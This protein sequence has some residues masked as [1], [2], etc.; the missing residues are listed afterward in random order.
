MKMQYATELHAH[1]CLVS[2]CA[3]LPLEDAVQRYAESG[4]HTVVV[5]DHYC[6]YVIDT[7]GET[8]EQVVAHYV[9]GYK[10]M[11][12]MAKGKFDV[13]LGC[14][15]RFVGSMNDYLV[16]G[17][18]EEFLLAHPDLHKMS[19]R[20]F[21]PFA[22]EHGLL[23]IQAHPFRKRMVVMDPRLLDG[24]EVFNGHRK[25]ESKNYLA[26]E[27]ANRYGL[28]K[29][30]GSDFH[31]PDSVISGGILTDE[32]ITSVSQLIEVL[33]GGNYTLICQGPAA[34]RDGMTNMPA[35]EN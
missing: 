35:K 34:E 25:H 9:S 33:R 22:R 30:S 19:L 17:M 28:I 6:D 14:E 26:N 29:T 1:T 12:E 5:T 13:L 23:L 15:L 8:W 7:A 4:Y 11:K 10:A 3:D 18:D 31:H 32:P 16:L 20:T 27:L 2:P 24:V 21:S